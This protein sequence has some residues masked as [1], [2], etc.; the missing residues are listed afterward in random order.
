MTTDVPLID[1]EGFT[2]D[3]TRAEEIAHR[4]DD[5]LCATGFFHITGH[6]VPTETIDAAFAASDRFFDLPLDRKL[7][8]RPPSPDI[9]RGYAPLGSESLSYSLGVARTPDHFE[10]FNV[11]PD[12]VPDGPP[13]LRT[14][15]WFVANIWPDEVP[16]LRSALM[17]YFD[18]ANRVAELLLGAF[19]IALGLPA[20][21]LRAHTT[22]STDTMRT[23]RYTAP[24]EPGHIDR[25]ADADG[26]LG[27]GAH[28]DY[29]IV[30]VLCADP[31]PGLEIVGSDGGWIP[32]TPKPGALVINIG[33]LL[34]QWTN[35]RWR[36]TIHRVVSPN[37]DRARRAVRRS[38]A[39]F[40]DGNYDAVI[41]CLPGC[42]SDTNPPRYPPVRAEDHLWNKLL[43]PRT[44]SRSEAVD[45]VGDRLPDARPT[46]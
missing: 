30:T 2:E 23:I 4:I 11:G 10:A 38:M 24:P 36:S 37:A 21:H 6:G 5:A 3:P 35:D 41:A 40:H 7:Q 15:S 12:E 19:E 25:P 18:H 17:T 43:G 26:R 34:A 16:E 14:D 22:H 28:T 32:V 27:M 31:V 8:A 42:S 9:N 44:L 29:G 46:I 20:G 13:Q 1:L 39:F 33:D 45:T